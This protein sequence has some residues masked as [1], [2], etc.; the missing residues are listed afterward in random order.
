MIGVKHLIVVIIGAVGLLAG[1]V[2]VDLDHSGTYS[3]K[4]RGFWGKDT[5]N[6]EILE[7]GIFH[8]P[9]VALSIMAFSLCLSI[10]IAIHY[11]MDYLRIE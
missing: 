7:R 10:G 9:M 2:L 5:S 4:W 8:N 6:C 11:I 3:C 1:N